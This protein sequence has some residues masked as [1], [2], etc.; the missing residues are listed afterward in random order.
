MVER[1][2]RRAKRV[3][4]IQRRRLIKA[5]ESLMVQYDGMVRNAQQQVVQFLYGEDGMD[6]ARV[7]FQSLPDDQ[8]IERRF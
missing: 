2:S 7:E 8:R 1:V 3:I 4:Y 6:G 5:M